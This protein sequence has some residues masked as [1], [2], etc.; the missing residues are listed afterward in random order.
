[1]MPNCKEV[2]RLLSDQ[3]ERP[4][5]FWKSLMLRLHL[6]MCKMC[7]GYA[8]DF[9]RLRAAVKRYANT[10]E[11]IDGE[12]SLCSQFPLELATVQSQCQS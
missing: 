7:G 6:T 12:P 8:R 10:E 3:T 9:S 4:L 11:S 1:M 5:P 2:A